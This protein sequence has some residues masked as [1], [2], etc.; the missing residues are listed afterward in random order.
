[1]APA[2]A[3]PLPG[4]EPAGGTWVKPALP[5]PAAASHAGRVLELSPPHRHQRRLG[6]PSHPGE[7]EGKAV[8]AGCC[9]CSLSGRG[10]G[11]R[12]WL[13]RA[14]AAPSKSAE[15]CWCQPGKDQS[16]HQRV[17]VGGLI[18]VCRS[19]MVKAGSDIIARAGAMKGEGG[20]V[21]G[22]SETRGSRPRAAQPQSSG[23]SRGATQHRGVPGLR[24]CSPQGFVLGCTGASLLR[25]DIL[26]P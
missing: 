3:I 20:R 25:L 11:P 17:C 2:C 6:K 16:L 8:R 15:R 18:F 26:P 7:E 24:L 14:G 22:G 4:Q 19:Q 12:G 21:P 9:P 23:S 13:L 5:S 1:M 10:T